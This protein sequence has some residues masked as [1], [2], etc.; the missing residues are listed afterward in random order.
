MSS[1]RQ[2]LDMLT[3]QAAAAVGVPAIRDPSK[4]SGLVASDAGGCLLVDLPTQVGRLLA[5]PNLEVPV[6]LITANP[7]DLRAVNW[8]L[9]RLDPFIAFTGS[10]SVVTGSTPIGDLTYPSVTATV[11]LT[12]TTQEA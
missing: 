3:E 11:Q 8:L 2:A 4:V 9:D 5:G 6:H 7:P 1:W 10:R 12:V